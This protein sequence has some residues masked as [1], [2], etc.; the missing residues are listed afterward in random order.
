M[1]DKKPV[2]KST[3]KPAKKTT[4]QSVKQSVKQVVNV[5]I[6]T[7]VKAKRKYTKRAKS[8]TQSAQSTAQAPI[9]ARPNFSAIP[10]S[11]T[12]LSNDTTF[13]S[14]HIIDALKDRN[15]PLTAQNSTTSNTRIPIYS[16]PPRQS[17]AINEP[18]QEPI[19]NDII[20]D[21]KVDESKFEPYPE[22]NLY[23]SLGNDDYIINPVPN[24]HFN[25]TPIVAEPKVQ[26]SKPLEQVDRV[27]SVKSL[28][29]N[30]DEKKQVSLDSK[31]DSKIDSRIHIINPNQRMTEKITD[32]IQRT[33]DSHD[34]GS[35]D[36]APQKV[37]ILSTKQVENGKKNIMDAYRDEE[38][39]LR[40]DFTI[41]SLEYKK[42]EKKL[43][44]D[45]EKELKVIV[46][47][48]YSNVKDKMSLKSFKER[49]NLRIPK[50][51]VK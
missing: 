32:I 12:G 14:K 30:R 9:I 22:Q 26:E 37:L 49:F 7:E 18:A 33:I 43:R 38:A 29:E 39:I 47:D 20:Y 50:H 19:I 15:A 10:V 1:T 4:K 13:L 21:N 5:N 48:A 2:K 27:K 16:E 8:S 45:F 42:R 25:A 36:S 24:T 44:S 40:D 34:I 28:V 31:M 11:S 3:K 35:T 17:I 6:G 51:K 23:N 46:N 41:D